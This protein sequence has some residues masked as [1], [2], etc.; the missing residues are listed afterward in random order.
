ML[1]F[2]VQFWRD[3][4]GIET[5]MI[6]HVVL[7]FCIAFG[8]GLSSSASGPPGEAPLVNDPPKGVSIPTIIQSF[9]A[10]ETVFRQARQRYTYTQ[11][12]TVSASCRG[13]LPG[14]YHL[15]ADLT[16]DDNGNWLERVKATDST[17]RCI[18]ITY[19]D[20]KTF[21]N[22]FL[23]LLTTDD[24]QN[25]RVNF[26]GQQ[27]DDLHCYVFDVSPVAVQPGKPQFEGR[28]WV[29][30][31]DFFIVKSYGTIAIKRKKKRNRQNL[32]PPVTTWR[33]QID[34]RYWFPTKTRANEVLHFATGD[35]RIDELVTLANYKPMSHSK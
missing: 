4:G 16:A 13:A 8:I 2:V 10:K 29:D 23:M 5:D 12:V 24:I 11:D 25:Y 7:I 3:F 14:S 31:H 15:I 1:I 26:V 17:L 19:E 35:M 27:Q 18:E 34:G 30:S 28:I 21:S 9:A 6:R 32:L 33:E 22:Q 20:L